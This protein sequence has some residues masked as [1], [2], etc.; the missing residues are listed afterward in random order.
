MSKRTVAEWKS[1]IQEVWNGLSDEH[2][3]KLSGIMTSRLSA[4]ITGDS[5]KYK[6]KV[7]NQNIQ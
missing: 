4:C 1:T 6:Y 3:N 7:I 5:E 2:L